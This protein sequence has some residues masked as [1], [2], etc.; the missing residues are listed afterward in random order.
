MA[1]PRRKVTE[2]EAAELVA[3]RRAPRRALPAWCAS[4]GIDGRSLRY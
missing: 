3:A 1:Q 4:H 2:K